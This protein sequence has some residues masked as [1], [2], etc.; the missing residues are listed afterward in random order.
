MSNIKWSF[1]K[2]YKDY[3]KFLNYTNASL[4]VSL[5]FHIACSSVYQCVTAHVYTPYLRFLLSHSVDPGCQLDSGE[6]V[7]I[8]GWGI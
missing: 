8:V 2:I 7:S 3:N 1:I 4:V 5:E 6:R